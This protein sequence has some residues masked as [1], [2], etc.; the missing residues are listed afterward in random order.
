[1]SYRVGV[2]IGGTF[3]DFFAFN[4]KTLDT[5][6]LK[7]LSTPQ[8]PGAEVVEGLRQLESRFGVP[9]SAITYFSHGTTVG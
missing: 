7:V 5:H 9:P 4:D 8:A 1:M 3:T 2:D 6:A